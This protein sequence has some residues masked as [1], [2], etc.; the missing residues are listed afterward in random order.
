MKTKLFLAVTLSIFAYTATQG[1]ADEPKHPSTEAKPTDAKQ[2]PVDQDTLER[3]RREVRLLD[4][5]YKSAI[6]LITKHYVEESSDLPAGEAFK[7]LFHSMDEKGWHEVR[8][9]DASGEP[10]NDENKPHDEFERRAIKVML[11]EKPYYEEVDIQKGE[12]FLRASTPIPVVM[13]KCIMCH[14][15]YRGKK[16]IG[17]LGYT[18]PLK[19][20]E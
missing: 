16:I 20:H 15:N 6:V 14:E 5:I 8:L 3:A 13:E 19:P 11:A 9:L 7:V 2:P 4:D 17:A 18:L 12:L 1:G 10:L